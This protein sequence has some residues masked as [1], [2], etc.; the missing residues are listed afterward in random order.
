LSILNSKLV[1]NWIRLWSSMGSNERLQVLSVFFISIL[2]SFFE[3][4]S[5]GSA[6]PFLGIIIAPDKLNEYPMILNIINE[7]GIDNKNSLLTF[8]TCFF[9]TFV[10]SA[11]LLRL[12][13]LYKQERSSYL[14]GSIIAQKVFRTSLYQN[15]SK[16]LNIN[17]SDLIATSSAKITILITH[18]LTPTIVFFSSLVILLIIAFII[19][20]INPK[21]ALMAIVFLSLLYLIIIRLIKSRIVYHSLNIS[22]KQTTVIKILQ[23]GFIGVRD[24]IV[25][26][27][28]EVY[29]KLFESSDYSLKRSQSNIGILAG[30]P[31]FIIEALL[32][33][34]FSLIVL[35]FALSE[36]GIMFYIPILGTVA[37]GAAR[38]LPLI[39]Q[40]YYSFATLSG[41][42]ASLEDILD[43]IQQA[44]NIKMNP[45]DKDIIQ[46]NDNITLKDVSFKYDNTST[47]IFKNL[48]I[49]IKKGSK[50]GIF[51]KSGCGKSTLLD[52]L[53][54]LL[55][56]SSGKIYVDNNKITSA[57]YVNWLPNI[58]N[59]PQTIFLSDSSILENIAFGIPR[60][61]I[62]MNRVESVCKQ[63]Q[64]LNHI[65]NLP[66]KF[67][68][69]IGE[70]GLRLS[71]GQRQRIGIARALYKKAK[72]L[73]FDE[74]TSALDSNTENEIINAIQNLNKNLTIFI[75]TH[76]LSSLKF[77]SEIFKIENGDIKKLAN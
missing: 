50:V 44:P 1:N 45:L 30:S 46:F 59:V 35:S 22:E 32:T 39:Q 62:D 61:M 75:V 5:I 57:N 14:I 55:N 66:D 53:I 72:V 17:S 67:D 20:L 65:S 71:G 33:V 31:R 19:I 26:G 56:P 74:A 18:I 69:I 40:I 24:I 60:N 13:L 27:T 42:Q 6:L 29:C 8:I 2:A 37:L 43:I 23:E 28:Q 38:T 15:Y 58:A 73:V 52:L 49:S 11:G 77:C 68:T 10:I 36:E 25:N 41:G 7:F 63:A 47:H 16:H 76:R 34:C 12:L 64:I 70:Q 21:V 48:N 51:G 54:G 3:V 9:V 4:A